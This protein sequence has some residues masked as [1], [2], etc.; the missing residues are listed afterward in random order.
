MKLN[1]LVCE[2]LFDKEMRSYATKLEQGFET[3]DYHT[4][5]RKHLRLQILMEEMTI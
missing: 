4:E 2:T 1:A 5:E 3:V